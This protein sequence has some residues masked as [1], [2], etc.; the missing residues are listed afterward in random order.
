VTKRK[1]KTKNQHQPISK[2]SP[3]LSSGSASKTLSKK[4][5]KR[6]FVSIIRSVMVLVVLVMV[7]G[8]GITALNNNYDTNHDLSVIGQGIP[9]VVQIHDPQCQL[10]VRLRSNANA[11]IARIADE[12]ILF[13][14]ADVTTPEGRSLQRKHNVPHV[15]LLLFDKDGKLNRSLNGVKTDDELHQIF[16]AHIN[17]RA[18]RS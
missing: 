6:Q 14:V 11:A 8:A 13:R 5:S 10:C 4:K 16:L 9:T 12:D 1:Q 17:R 3:S 15:T 2:K 18:N 7:G